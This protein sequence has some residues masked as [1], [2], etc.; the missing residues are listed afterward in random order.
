M[1]KRY[2]YLFLFGI[3]GFILSLMASFAFVGAGTG[4]LWLF[5]FGDET[6]PSWVEAILPIILIALILV[7]WVIF[8]LIGFRTGSKLESEPG[9]DKQHILI[10]G[11]LTI[12]FIM[13]VVFQQL[14]VGKL[15]PKLDS[16]VCSDY[17]LSLG[18]SGSGM[19]PR[20]SGDRTC[21]CYDDL[22]NEA[23]KTQLDEIEALSR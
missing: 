9:I 8:L 19:P 12:L 5:V 10:S 20:N 4:L 11:G 21:S 7:I 6:W 13:L 17:C 1:K 18:Y 23:V 15:G 16:Q 3:P 22:G 14:R 2:L